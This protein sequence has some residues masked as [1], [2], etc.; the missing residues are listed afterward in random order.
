LIYT[1]RFLQD[2]PQAESVLIPDMSCIYLAK[3]QWKEAA[4]TLSVLEENHPQRIELSAC[5]LT[6]FGKDEDALF[7]YER[8][9]EQIRRDNGKRRPTMT[10][11]GLGSLMYPL[12]LLRSSN[13]D[14]WKK[15][16]EYLKTAQNDEANGFLFPSDYYPLVHLAYW[17]QHKEN[18]LE[19]ETLE[20]S[21]SILY[22]LRVLIAYWTNVGGWS[23]S[24]LK[25]LLRRSEIYGYAFWK[26]EISALLS[27]IDAAYT[28]KYAE[29][30]KERKR[31]SRTLI[32]KE[33]WERALDSLEMTALEIAKAAEEE[34]VQPKETRLIWRIAL[35]ENPV[36]I[37]PAEQIKQK[38]G[39]WSKGREV[40][41]Q[42]LRSKAGSHFTEQDMRIVACFNPKTT[43]WYGNTIRYELENP[44]EG[45]LALAGHPLVFREDSAEVGLSIVKIQ[46]SVTAQEKGEYILLSFNPDW[47]G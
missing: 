16:E 20:K 8:A 36:R 18:E 26:Q 38:T 21:L 39:L 4:R 43:H 10:L 17:R 30:E 31:L 32:Y 6:I 11:R 19:K 40:S 24:A 7:Q 41:L 22:G 23:I 2:Y 14:K 45:L 46:P 12:T 13:P 9:L 3:G 1:E 35:E 44:E 37:I 47:R 34:S 15:A 25:T 33:D 29:E 28:D 5:L 42:N 27:E